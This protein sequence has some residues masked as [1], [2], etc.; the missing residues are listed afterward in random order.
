MPKAINGI[1]QKFIFALIMGALFF[2]P[3]AAHADSKLRALDTVANFET[4][5][6]AFDLAPESRIVFRVQNPENTFFEINGETDESGYAAVKVPEFETLKAGTYNV[7]LKNY[8]FEPVSFKV[9]PGEMSAR[10]SEIFSS[11]RTLSAT[12]FDNASVNVKI[13]DEFGNPLRFHEVKLISSR[14]TDQI[15]AESNE[16]NTEG[17]VRFSVSSRQPGVATF[18]ASDESAGETLSNRIEIFFEQSGTTNSLRDV[19]GDVENRVLVAQALPGNLSANQLARFEIENLAATVNANETLSFRLRAVNAAGATV[20]TYTGTVAFTSTDSNAQMPAQYTFL[21]ADQGSKTFDLGLS[22][23]TSGSQTLTVRD[24]ANSLIS[25]QKNV[26][27]LAASTVRDAQV[28]LTKPAPGTYTSN[29]RE[30]AGEVNPNARVRIFDNGQQIAEV[31]ANA[32]GRFSYFTSALAD[33]QHT[34]T[35]ESGGVQ[36]SPSQIIIDS[37][38]SQTQDVRIEPQNIAPGGSFQITVRSDPDL[39]SIQ[40]TVGALIADLDPVANNPGLYSGTLR[41]PEQSGDHPINIIITDAVGNASQLTEAGILHVDSALTPQPPSSFTVPSRV[42][43]V[44]AAPNNGKINLTWD[45]SQAENGIALYRIYYGTNSNNLNLVAN[46]AGPVTAFEIPNLQNGTTYYFQV[47][48]VDTQGNEGDS[49]S[50]IV[51]ATS[52]VRFSSGF[53]VLCDPS[54]CPSAPFAPSTP[55]DGPGVVGVLIASMFGGG[56]LRFLRKRKK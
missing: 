40:A 25:G 31:Q 53:P 54:P 42:R 38:P 46:T 36:S 43:G 12:G 1:A 34:F 8:S 13:V 51:S 21:P 14:R 47:V 10:K 30:V 37:T 52:S 39:N 24:Q 29:V 6:E 33:G 9:F 28:R 2:I 26:Q 20:S 11:K 15:S 35:V 16:T 7:N 23:R 55:Q 50:D 44:R 48:G 45:A 32:S 56:V 22:F 18:V 17:I 41:A 49:R 19:G 5:I 4:K 3:Q 27:V